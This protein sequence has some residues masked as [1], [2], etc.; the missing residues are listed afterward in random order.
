MLYYGLAETWLNAG[1]YVLAWSVIGR[2][3]V[4][5]SSLP[6]ALFVLTIHMLSVCHQ[7]APVSAA[8]LFSKGSAKWY[9][10]CVIM[11]VKDPLLSV[12]RIGHRAPLEG[13]CLSKYSLH[14]LNRDVNMIQTNN[15]STL[16]NIHVL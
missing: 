4:C 14:V 7:L 1:M 2:L 11:H 9:Y 12:V 15:T 13:F 6:S 10:V 8:D 5:A 3:M 16:P